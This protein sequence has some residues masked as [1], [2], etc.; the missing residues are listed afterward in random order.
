[1]S[2]AVS[3]ESLIDLFRNYEFR[4]HRQVFLL[5]GLKGGNRLVFGFSWLSIVLLVP[6]FML[7]VILFHSFI[8]LLL[9]LIL[10]VLIAICGVPMFFRII[11]EENISRG[12]A[13]SWVAVIVSYFIFTCLWYLLAFSFGLLLSILPGLLSSTTVLFGFEADFVGVEVFVLGVLLVYLFVA[14]MIVYDWPCMYGFESSLL[15]AL[16]DGFMLPVYGLFI[17]VVHG[18]VDLALYLYSRDFYIYVYVAVRKRI[19]RFHD[20]YFFRKTGVRVCRKHIADLS[21]D[22]VK[23]YDEVRLNY[24]DRLR[25]RI[26]ISIKSLIKLGK[27]HYLGR[28]E[29]LMSK[30]DEGFREIGDAE[31]YAKEYY[32]LLNEIDSVIEFLKKYFLALIVFS[33]IILLL[34]PNQLFTSY[35][36]STIINH[37]V[38]LIILAMFYMLEVIVHRNVLFRKLERDKYPLLLNTLIGNVEDVVMAIFF[39]ES[40]ITLSYS[41]ASKSLTS[42]TVFMVATLILCIGYKVRKRTEI[43]SLK[44][45]TYLYFL[46]VSP[47]DLVLYDSSLEKVVG[48]IQ[49]IGE[50]TNKRFGV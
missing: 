34:L 37:Y 29:A 31:A 2:S 45:G 8:A 3:V 33:L 24:R 18:F 10:P 9:S 15:R 49:N 28:L 40:L 25:A 35:I 19:R 14:L 32:E 36:E 7:S 27:K 1:M 48:I 44:Y 43:E 4:S 30:Y 13:R 6:T 38:V 21:I 50:F 41:I 39:I 12:G 17:I 16:L 42:S 46:E 23:R 26:L 20:D 11:A 47:L 22:P 5:R